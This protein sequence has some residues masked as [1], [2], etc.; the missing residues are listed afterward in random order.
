MTKRMILPLIFGLSGIAIL[1][2][3]G[4]WQMQRL[5]WKE[6]L[7]KQVEAELVS[8]PISL[9]SIYKTGGPVSDRNRKRVSFAGE[10]SNQEAFIYAPSKDGLGYRVV[11]AFVWNHSS[12]LLD[13][14]WI[15]EA[16][17]D[18]QRPVGDMRVIGHVLFPDDYDASFTP[19]PDLAENIFFS[20]HIPP[21]AQALDVDPFM[22]VVETAEL[23]VDG[24]WVP[25]QSVTPQ[26]VNIDFKNDHKEYA[27]TWFSLAFVWFG[28]TVYLLWR[29]RQKTV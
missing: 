10:I 11:V 3:L 26:P 2:S 15:P 1:L 4:M 7:V 19:D 9:L 5:V 14:G 25:Y 17:K 29:I 13:L 23:R 22:V 24:E 27:I 8:D 16:A 28:M 12:F 6:A 20:R 21:L 18:V